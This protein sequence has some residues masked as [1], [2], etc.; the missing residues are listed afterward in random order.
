MKTVIVIK[1]NEKAVLQVAFPARRLMV[2][3]VVGAVGDV[4]TE[5]T[6]LR[7]THIHRWCL[8]LALARQSVH[9]V[10][11]D[12]DDRPFLVLE[13]TVRASFLGEQVGELLR[14]AQTT[15][16]GEPDARTREEDGLGRLQRE[17]F[18]EQVVDCLNDRCR[19]RQLARPGVGIGRDDDGG[20][21]THCTLL[22]EPSLQA[23]NSYCEVQYPQQN[24]IAYF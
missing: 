23:G 18:V 24:S 9:P 10:L 3:E 4:L 13:D 20:V 15:G 19:V 5:P 16:A 7:S 1:V 21:C 8:A 12:L 17:L 22:K 2:S 14:P 11:T 6:I